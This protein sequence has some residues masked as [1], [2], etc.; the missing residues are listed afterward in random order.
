M[1]KQSIAGQDNPRGNWD[2]SKEEI[3]RRGSGAKPRDSTTLNGSIER[4]K[5]RE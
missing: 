2:G 3:A 4:R 5:E 1:T